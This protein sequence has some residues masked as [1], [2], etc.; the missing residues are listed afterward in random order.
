MYTRAKREAVEANGPFQLV[1][2]ESCEPPH[3]GAAGAWYQYTISQGDNVIN[4]VR[5]GSRAA[6]T[7]AATQVVAVLN[8]RRGDRRGRVH[9]VIQ[10]KKS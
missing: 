2:V 8:E 6:V 5:R 7:S 1:A 3:D 10:G 9:L 4:C